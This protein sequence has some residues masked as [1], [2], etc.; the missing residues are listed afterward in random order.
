MS[1]QKG[2]IQPIIILLGLIIFSSALIVGSKLKD[3]PLTFPT[4]TS[5][6]IIV[7]PSSTPSPSPSPSPSPTPT[8]KP[9]IKPT[10]TPTTAPTTTTGIPGNGY[11]YATIVTDRGT[12]KAHI[13]TLN[14]PTMVTDTA[15]DS[16]CA[17]DCPT[18]PLA[19]YVSANGG[20]AG[21][22]GTY[23]CP[24]DYADC[25]S[26][27][28]S[29]DFPVYNTRLS[30]WI[31][32]DKLGWN[33]R[34]IVYQDGGGFRYLQNANSFNGGLSAGIV[35]YPGLLAGSQITVNQDPLSEKQR[36]K[37]TKGGIGINGNKVFLV[38]ASGV[39]TLDFATIFKAIGATDALNLDGGGSVAMY[40]GGRY[41]VGPG[42][43]L[44]NAIVFK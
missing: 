16:D 35:N 33:D 2:I 12:F 17:A 1:A 25:A 21:I 31:N 7:S 26:K 8:P 41:V 3:N 27:K 19:D 5:S 39:D 18:K 43:S 9:T 34:A 10:A 44:P 40:Y 13:T 42:R 4:P 28:N 24:A 32:Q 29:F 23:S 15:S 36:S 14:N 11:G 37:G 22:H 38:V 20:F 30:K 6:P